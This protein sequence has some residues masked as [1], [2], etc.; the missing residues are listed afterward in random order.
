MA[1]T[2]TRAANNEPLEPLPLPIA[3]GRQRQHI[4]PIFLATKTLHA[5]KR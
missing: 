3:R 2:L 5:R 4:A 1:I